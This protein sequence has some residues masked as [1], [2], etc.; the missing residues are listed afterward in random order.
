MAATPGA[1][2]GGK[3]RA[4][5][6]PVLEEYLAEGELLYSPDQ[7]ILC[8]FVTPLAAAALLAINYRH[9][10]HRLLAVT[11]LLVGSMVPWRA[12]GL[13]GLVATN[14]PPG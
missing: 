6:N 7:V 5:T 8:F 9:L 13:D 11:T 2:R 3:R 12:T 4:A 10:G 1:R 14:R